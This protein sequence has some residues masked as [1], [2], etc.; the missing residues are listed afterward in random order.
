MTGGYNSENIPKEL[1][2]QLRKQMGA[3]VPPTCEEGSDD[4]NSLVA[5]KAKRP[6]LRERRTVARAVELLAHHTK[7]RNPEGIALYSLMVTHRGN[8]PGVLLAE[9]GPK[10]ESFIRAELRARN[11]A[12][13]G[14]HNVVINQRSADSEK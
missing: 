5:R 7:M 14:S 3:L 4:G 13:G 11:I 9:G 10:M 2:E 1:G 6:S 8:V 12:A